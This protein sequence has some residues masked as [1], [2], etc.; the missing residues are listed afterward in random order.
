MNILGRIDDR[1][2]E[3]LEKRRMGFYVGVVSN[4]M[5]SFRRSAVDAEWGPTLERIRR[6]SSPI[7]DVIPARGTRMAVLSQDGVPEFGAVVGKIWDELGLAEH[8]T[9]WLRAN[10]EEH[11]GHI[12]L[13]ADKGLRIVVGTNTVD[14][15][16]I[17]E[18]RVEI[19]ASHVVVDSDDIR[20]VDESADDPVPL[21]SLVEGELDD[22]ESTLGPISQ[23]YNEGVAAAQ[24]TPGVP[25][26]AEWTDEEVL[27]EPYSAGEVGS[28]HVTAE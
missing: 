28:D 21:S 25:V 22:I 18:G 1:V 13:G 12:E 3:V 16:P 4:A 14:I 2:R 5:Q 9:A 15:E 20:L 27:A 8:M 23:W 10:L 19:V 6:I 26:N 7:L 17:E 24:A 11:P